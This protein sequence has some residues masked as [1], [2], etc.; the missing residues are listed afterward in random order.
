MTDDQQLALWLGATRYYL[1]RETYAV[2]QFCDILIEAWPALSKRTQALI[3]RD[4]EEAFERDD[5]ARFRVQTW[6]PLGRDCDR[7]QWERVRALWGQS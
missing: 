4:I 3:R 1:G 7:A 6:I 2:G 5:A